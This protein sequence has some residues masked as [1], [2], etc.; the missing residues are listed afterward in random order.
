M[1]LRLK[2]LDVLGSY[3]RLCGAETF[4]VTPAKRKGG[5][6]D[7]KMT[8]RS[9]YVIENKGPARKNEPKTDPF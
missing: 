9:Q 6:K 5:K 4:A 3:P 7:G 2:R 8:E 1:S